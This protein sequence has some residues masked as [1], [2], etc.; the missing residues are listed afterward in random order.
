MI[1]NTSN[2]LRICITTKDAVITRAAVSTSY[3]MTIVTVRINYEKLNLFISIAIT[4]AINE[5][6]PGRTAKEVEVE[7]ERS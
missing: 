2:E 6:E 5:C 1:L 3:N 7:V 4:I